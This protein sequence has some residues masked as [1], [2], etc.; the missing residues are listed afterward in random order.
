[1]DVRLKSRGRLQKDKLGV[2]QVANRILKEQF[3]YNH[4]A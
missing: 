3:I 4:A 2:F 1:M